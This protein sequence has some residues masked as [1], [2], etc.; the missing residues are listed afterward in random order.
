M[1][2]ILTRDGEI[3]GVETAEG[4]IKT[5]VVVNSCGA[6]SREIANML[7]LDIPLVPMKHAYVVT[8][9]MDKVKGVPNVRD[10]DFS[11]YFRIQGES[12]CMGGYEK[13]PEILHEYIPQDFHFGLYD[14]NYDVFGAHIKEATELCPAFGEAGIKS[15][16]C[17]PE[18]FTPDHKPI[19]GEDVRQPG[20]VFWNKVGNFFHQ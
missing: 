11:I 16:V 12:I 4:L 3:Y 5:K 13:N 17:G 2:K 7:N 8:E 10:H 15:T 14:L 19:V 6:W 20:K 9:S 18:S 1:K